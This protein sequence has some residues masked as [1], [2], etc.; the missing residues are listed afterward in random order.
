MPEGD[1]AIMG[2]LGRRYVREVFD[3]ERALGKVTSIV[4]SQVSRRE[5]SSNSDAA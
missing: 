2:E 5:M 3:R 4:L 1:L